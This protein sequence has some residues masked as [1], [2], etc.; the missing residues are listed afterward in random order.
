M[1]SLR[2]QKI[3]DIL[4]SVDKVV[5]GTQICNIIGVSERTVRSD[6]KELNDILKNSGAIIICEKAKGYKIEILDEMIF[7]TFYTKRKNQFDTQNLSTLGRAEYI[8]VQLLINE[9]TGIEAVTQNELADVLYVSLSSLKNDLKLAKAK[10]LNFDLLIEKV[11]NKGLKITGQE[12]NVRSCIHAYI[13]A[14]NE[15]IKSEV[16]KLLMKIIGEKEVTLDDILKSNMKKFDFR[17]SDIAYN[18]LKSYL[19]IILIR[20]TQHKYLL[21]DEEASIALEK[22]PKFKVTQNICSDIEQFLDVHLMQS[23]V[24]YMTKHIISSS[25]ITFGNDAEQIYEVEKRDIVNKILNSINEVFNIDFSTD[26]ILVKFLGNHLSISINK[27]RYGIRVKNTMLSLIKNNYPFA[28]ELALV[29]NEVIKEEFGFQLIEDEIGFIALHFAAAIERYNKKEEVIAKKVIIVCSSGIGTSL[30]LKVKLEAHFKNKINIID[31]IS[32]YE[33]NE[34][35]LENVDLII[36][37]IDVD[38]ELDKLIYVRS[39]LNDEEI[40]LVEEKLS[41]DNSKTGLLNKLREELFF[42]KL[43]VTDKENLLNILTGKLIDMNY[44]NEKVR[45]HIFKREALT[46]TEIGSL[47]AIPHVMHDDIKESFI[48]VATLKKGITWSQE[49]VQ[50]VLL[51]GMA[52]KDKYEWKQCLECLYRNITD[53]DVVQE[54]LQCND[55]QGLQKIVQKF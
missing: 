51:I 14:Q 52:A 3:L 46:S 42:E 36:S 23:E 8:V 53:I 44:I 34:E 39:L 9:L 15:E 17:I 31:T 6:I 16:S 12:E 29:T 41:D 49:Q 10:L 5:T 4:L 37:T 54:I 33:I 47:V 32:W 38:I 55:F 50:L 27:A 18:D 22:E 30:L 43:V 19:N 2:M 21:Y 28:V 48:M 25:Y 24:L 13:A 35:V 26:Q 7:S 20:S 40:R 45:M 1:F 11:G